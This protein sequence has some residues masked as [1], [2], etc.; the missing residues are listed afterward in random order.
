M[1]DFIKFMGY[2]FMGVLLLVVAILAAPTM[3]EQATSDR[4]QHPHSGATPECPSWDISLEEGMER[5]EAIRSY[6]LGK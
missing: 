1:L 2:F 4:S 6:R 5:A 3:W